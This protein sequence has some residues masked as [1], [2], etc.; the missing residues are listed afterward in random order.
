MPS[1]PTPTPESLPAMP[2]PAQA[3]AVHTC[4][5]ALSTFI[6]LRFRTF[7]IHTPAF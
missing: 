2:C 4:V 6:P 7:F 3:N 5:L 1:I